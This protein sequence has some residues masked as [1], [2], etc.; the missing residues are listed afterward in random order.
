MMMGV[1]AILQIVFYRPPS[2]HQLHGGKRTIVQELKRVDFVGIFLM[3][4]G[5][6][7]FLLGVSW[8]L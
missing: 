1:A 2:F 7:M 5:L 3:T 4:A 6:S 8:G